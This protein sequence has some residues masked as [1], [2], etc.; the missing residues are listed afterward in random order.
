[1]PINPDITPSRYRIRPSIDIAEAILRRLN[2]HT[3]DETR[4]ALDDEH[5]KVARRFD[6]LVGIGFGTVSR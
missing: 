1:M 3:T 6:A 5:A 4:K 2:A